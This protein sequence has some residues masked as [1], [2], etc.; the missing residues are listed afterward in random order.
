MCWKLGG[1]WDGETKLSIHLQIKVKHGGYLHSDQAK[2][3]RREKSEIHQCWAGR[4]KNVTFIVKKKIIKQASNTKW[5]S[6]ELIYQK[7]MGAN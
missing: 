7:I 1:L 2:G 5:L 4:N 3:S 6:L